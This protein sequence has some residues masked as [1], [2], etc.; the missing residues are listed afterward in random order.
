ME[1]F[2]RDFE[3]GEI[4]WGSAPNPASLCKGL[5]ETF[6]RFAQSG[7][8]G[9]QQGTIAINVTYLMQYQEKNKAGES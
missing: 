7:R 9:K 5:T 3:R 6:G 2:W 8:K 4:F 1:R